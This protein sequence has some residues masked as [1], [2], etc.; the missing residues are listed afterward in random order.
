MASL[1]LLIVT[2]WLIATRRNPL[3]AGIP[4]LFMYITTN[5]AALVTAYNL[6][7]TVFLRN[8]GVPGR[9]LAVV[10]SGLMIF[11]AL[12]LVGAAVLIGIDGYRAVQR[13]RAAPGPQ[14]A[15]APTS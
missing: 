7:N 15:P 1:S 9:E 4:M 10:G 3:Y 13:Y 6:W 11:V 5:A 12:L 14:P 8:L 2:V